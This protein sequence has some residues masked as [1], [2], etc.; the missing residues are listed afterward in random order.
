MALFF[1][2]TTVICAVGWFCSKLSVMTLLCFLEE[3]NCTLPTKD[4]LKACSRKAAERMLQKLTT[5]GK[6]MR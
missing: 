3:K 1:L 6:G 2:A 5:A 4:E